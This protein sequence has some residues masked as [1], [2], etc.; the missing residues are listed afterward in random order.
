M[1]AHLKSIVLNATSKHTATVIFLHVSIDLVCC[2]LT[3][4][5]DEITVNCQG[6]GDTGH[7][8]SPF[9]EGIIRSHPGLSHVKWILPHA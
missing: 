1:S 2:K 9:V 6:L 8:W 4:F 3:C 7:G 5:A